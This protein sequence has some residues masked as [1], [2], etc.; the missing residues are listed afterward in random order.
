VWKTERRE[1]APHR[2]RGHGGPFGRRHS[3]GELW[4]YEPKWDGFRCL[5][6]REGEQVDLHSKS[7]QNLNRYFPEVIAGALAVREKSFV[8]DG[9]IVVPTGSQFSFDNLL[10]RIHP[11]ASRVKKTG[12]R[13][14]GLVP[15]V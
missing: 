1:E 14:P 11:A 15:R 5:L 2:H 10:R 6:V 13:D 8:L 9:E 12:G 4:R 7:G 3:T